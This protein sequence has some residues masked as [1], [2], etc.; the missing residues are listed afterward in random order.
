MIKLKQDLGAIEGASADL[1]LKE[2]IYKV[3]EGLA[4]TIMIDGKFKITSRNDY[5]FGS[6]PALKRAKHLTLLGDGSTSQLLPDFPSSMQAIVIGGLESLVIKD[7]VI[8]GDPLKQFDCGTLFWLT[9]TSQIIWDKT[10]MYGLASNNNP[11]GIVFV[12]NAGFSMRDSLIKGSTSVDAGLFTIRHARKTAIKNVEFL[13]YGELDT[14]HLKPDGSPE[15]Y[16]SKTSLGFSH[17]WIK[18]SD[19]HP[20]GSTGYLGIPLIEQAKFDEGAR[21]GVSCDGGST[22]MR[23]IR[24]RDVSVNVRHAGMLFNKVENVVI[25]DFYSTWQMNPCLAIDG[26]DVKRMRLTRS[27]AD[28]EARVIK[29]RRSEDRPI[30][31]EDR[32]DRLILDDCEGFIVDAPGTMVMKEP[33]LPKFIG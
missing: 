8:A 20:M 28:R 18:F 17:S 12:D 21:Y 9:T 26:T 29:L 2:A 16:R 15:V 1:K 32:A 19:P 4:S 27:V 22:W 5:E 33:K 11:H 25:E 3:G 31:A 10:H 13:D 7:L 14:G 23:G 6:N 24:F 30:T